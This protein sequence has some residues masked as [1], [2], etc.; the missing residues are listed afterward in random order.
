[1]DIRISSYSSNDHFNLHLGYKYIHTAHRMVCYTAFRYYARRYVVG[2][3][4]T[5]FCACWHSNF[6]IGLDKHKLRNCS[7]F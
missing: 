6:N 7:S 3:L 5:Y 1:M 4:H 2:Y